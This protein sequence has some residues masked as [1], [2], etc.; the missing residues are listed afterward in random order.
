MCIKYY[1]CIHMESLRRKQFILPQSK[2]NQ[3]KKALGVKTDTDAVILS[4]EAVLRQESLEKF[5]Q[6]GG[7][8]R[9]KLTPKELERMRRG[10]H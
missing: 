9:L 3:V 5:S 8:L 1:V 6:M 10:S 2:L 7:R 4:L